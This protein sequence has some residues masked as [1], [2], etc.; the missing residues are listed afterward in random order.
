MNC[1]NCHDNIPDDAILRAL[2]RNK[3]RRERG[4]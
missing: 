4:E 1:L 2:R 3:V